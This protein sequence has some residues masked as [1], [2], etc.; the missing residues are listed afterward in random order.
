MTAAASTPSARLWD[1]QTSTGSLPA[2]GRAGELKG[3]PA[4]SPHAALH[5]PLQMGRGLHGPDLT[6]INALYP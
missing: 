6:E 3:I 2:P 4:H 5:I 1:T